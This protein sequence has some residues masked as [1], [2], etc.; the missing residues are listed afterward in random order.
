[1]NE[2]SEGPVTAS[3]S[4]VGEENETSNIFQD[5]DQISR[6]HVGGKT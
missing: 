1:M 2:Q 5:N 3:D 6:T 4:S